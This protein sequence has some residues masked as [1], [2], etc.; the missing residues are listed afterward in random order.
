MDSLNTGTP[1]DVDLTME[2]AAEAGTQYLRNVFGLYLEGAYVYMNYCPGTETFPV[3]F[4]QEMFC[5]RK[6]R[7]LR[8]QDG[9]T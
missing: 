9:H 6:S 1:T 5:F 2:E 7:R 8:A 3:L 4:G